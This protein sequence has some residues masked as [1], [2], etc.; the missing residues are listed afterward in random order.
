MIGIQTDRPIRQVPRT[1]DSLAT[2]TY[3]ASLPRS[4]TR[5]RFNYRSATLR[6]PREAFPTNENAEIDSKSIGRDHDPMD[7]RTIAKRMLPTLHEDDHYIFVAKPAGLSVHSPV[8]N[9]PWGLV[10]ILRDLTNQGDDL[11]LTVCYK[12]ERH[13]SGVLAVAKTSDAAVRLNALVKAG[14][15]RR[16]YVAIVKGSPKS[17]AKPRRTGRATRSA[18]PAA[19]RKSGVENMPDLNVIRQHDRYALVRFK[20]DGRGGRAL[21]AMM[22]RR[23][24][25][26][27]DNEF[28]RHPQK[29]QS[30]RIW[31][32]LE[33]VEFKHPFSAETVR[34][35]APLSP[36]FGMV[37]AGEDQLADR[38]ET[39][40]A[41]RMPCLL[42][43]N[44]NAYRLL[45][46]RADGVSG[47]IADRLGDVIVLQAQRGKFQGG[48]ERIRAAAAW[49]GEMFGARAVYVKDI[50]RDR[51]HAAESSLEALQNETPM[52]GEAADPEIEI[53]ENGLAFLVR[54]YD[55]YAVGL[56]L[57]HRENRRRIRSLSR[58][59]SVLNTFA[60]TCAFSVS[61]AA[62]GASSTVSVDVSKRALEWGK[63]NF[64]ATDVA[65]TNHKFIC[66]DT[67]DYFKRAHR[68]GHFFDV[69]ILDPPTFSRAKKPARVFEVAKDMSRLVAEA[70]TI[71][72]PK[73]LMMISTNHQDLSSTWLRRQITD[74]ARSRRPTFLPDTAS[75]PDIADPTRTAK[76]VFARFEA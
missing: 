5:R 40:L 20:Y 55:G 44:T 62:G 56:F 48:D 6:H 54:P 51:S 52:W 26:H 23:T 68:Q 59:Q 45:D 76:T 29:K 42:D 22:A 75:A 17:A 35:K 37:A 38:L 19:P 21:R 1:S 43:P 36:S 65:L 47:L 63:R 57:D 16:Q 61:A 7:P 14:G 34:I 3:R 41:A 30:G 2:R 60:Y 31:F 69:I 18:P 70:L 10:E 28:D 9:R 33:T 8:R 67:F 49:Y 53:R 39:G 72:A 46:G 24:P 11:A 64:A 50:P 27:G 66:S 15:L 73:G 71:L 25:I 13:T 32:H 4:S 12:L 58:N 74:A